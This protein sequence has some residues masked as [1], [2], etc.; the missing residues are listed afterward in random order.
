M[1]VTYERKDMRSL[2]AGRSGLTLIEVMIALVVSSLT[3]GLAWSLYHGGM[4]AYHR[5]L[6]EVALTQEARAVLTIMTRDIQ[7]ILPEAISY[8]L[9]DPN[10][11]GVSVAGQPEAVDRLA[12]TTIVYP[13]ADTD[14]AAAERMVTVQRVRYFLEP[15]TT[16]GKLTLKRAV[17]PQGRDGPG[18]V[19][20]LSERVHG[21]DLRYFDGHSWY[22]EWQHP[23][24]PRAL[25]IVIAL[26]DGGRDS[27]PHRFV[28][29]VAL[30]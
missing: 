13:P 25:E 3:L 26:Q 24:L 29:L 2:A 9:A 14:P 27:R 4:R 19:I 8:D 11:R 15:A 22:D 17:T 10:R 1:A 20:V 21:L 7:R 12:I 18:S 5:G 23:G 30:E 28:S 6:H 16:G